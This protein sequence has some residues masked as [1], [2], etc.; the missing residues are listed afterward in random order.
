MN[1][2][3]VCLPLFA[4]SALLFGQTKQN[5]QPKAV[6]FTHV[7]VIDAT[8]S[9]PQPAMTVVV[10]KERITA[11]GKTG[12]VDI[13]QDAQ[14]VDATGKYLIPGLWD[15]HVHTLT[16]KNTGTN[17]GTREMHGTF[18]P[19][20]I[21]N[22]VTGVRDMNGDLELLKQLRLQ[23]AS[24]K[25]SGPR[26][27]ASGPL[28]DG[29]KWSFGSIASTNEAEGREAVKSLKKRGADFVKV[30]NL[31]RRDTYFAIADE[32]EKQ[33][34]PFVGHVPFSVGPVDASE[35]GQKSIEHLDGVLPAC[36]I[37]EAELIKEK[38]ET[39]ARSG[40]SVL[41]VTRIRAEAK[42]LD[43]YSEQKAAVLFDHFVRNKTW[44]VPTL[45]LKRATAFIDDSSF[46][47]DPRLKY[48]PQYLR[49]TWV[50]GGG[51]YN[52]LVGNHTADDFADEKRILQKQIEIVGAM[53][54][55]GVKFMPGTDAIDPYIFPGFSV[56]DEIEMFVQAGFTP[57]EALQSATRNPAEF[58]GRL[59]DLGTV[60][61][62]KLADLVLLDANPLEDIRNTQRI[63]AV[64]VNGRYL[65]RAELNNMLAQVE[66]AAKNAQ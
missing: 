35:A 9:P 54:S 4:L 14:T 53:H 40:P 26:I 58:L 38:T 57:M 60:E 13:P 24:R 16:S 11:L 28:L 48:I 29:V 1:R 43:T 42:S 20:F 7:T 3:N 65:D 12:E 52:F 5:P 15:M 37:H 31:L 50:K 10:N 49:K 27:V 36:S 46:T 59:D 34:I 62:G 8:G 17:T 45:V 64:V 39:I 2:I 47:S 23:M 66:V 22:G 18:F 44:H 63:W 32:A 19:L 56:H 61:E 55:A 33:R 21:A 51:G 6:V 25:L 30:V 41:W